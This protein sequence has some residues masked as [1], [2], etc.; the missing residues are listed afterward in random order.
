MNQN[1]DIYKI[2]TYDG[3]A[4]NAYNTNRHEDWIVSKCKWFDN[5]ESA[6][7]FVR[8][9]SILHTDL[10]LFVGT[11]TGLD[12]SK[13]INDFCFDD[14]KYLRYRRF[15]IGPPPLKEIKASLKHNGIQIIK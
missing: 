8:Y 2:S 13:Y 3:F 12:K 10:L 9:M 11:L 15:F 14:D 4:G 7:E 1:V 6:M 5:M